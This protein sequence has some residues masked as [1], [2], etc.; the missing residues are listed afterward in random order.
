M[1]QAGILEEM[2]DDTMDTLD[3]DDMEDDVDAE[4]AKVLDELTSGIYC[5]ISS[6]FNKSL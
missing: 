3:E 2:L 1:F 4:V 5:Y 6:F